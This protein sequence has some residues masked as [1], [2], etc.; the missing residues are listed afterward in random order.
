MRSQ[1]SGSSTASGCL[2]AADGEPRDGVGVEAVSPGGL[3]RIALAIDAAVGVLTGA[4]WADQSVRWA[5]AAQLTEARLALE[6]LKESLLPGRPL[7]S[8]LE[9][10]GNGQ[11]AEAR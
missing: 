1:T 8:A 10:S 3:E 6:E 11:V 7:S 2:G 4:V 9:A 5:L